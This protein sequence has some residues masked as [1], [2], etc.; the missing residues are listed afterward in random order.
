MYGSTRDR[1]AVADAVLDDTAA[2]S[3]SSPAWAKV[4]VVLACLAASATVGVVAHRAAFGVVRLP[5][6][7]APAVECDQSDT[8]CSA[9]SSCKGGTAI[10]EECADRSG[11]GENPCTCT[12][13]QDLA[14]MSSDL[15]SEA[16]WNDLANAAYCQSG[17]LHVECNTVDG[18]QLPTLV[19]GANQGLAGA[20]PPSLG[21][22]GPSL[23][24]LNLGGNAITS[25]PTEIGALT[26]L[27][28]CCI[29]DN[30][31]GEDLSGGL[32]HTG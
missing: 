20:L 17:P 31:C 18:V 1:Q 12:A 26:G 4:G 29:G 32:C 9:G 2:S 24:Y 8:V 10:S 25:V 14:G 28:T 13:L 22:L 5:G 3:A 16:P 6:V 30:N 15:Q 23:T 19:D 11:F 21:E 27:T 7:G